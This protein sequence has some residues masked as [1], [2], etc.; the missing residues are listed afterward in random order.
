MNLIDLS[1]AEL[2][3]QHMKE[4][5]RCTAK[6]LLKII[7]EYGTSILPA[8]R[9]P[10][11]HV[12]FYL[13][14]LDLV[15]IDKTNYPSYTLCLTIKGNNISSVESAFNLSMKDLQKAEKMVQLEIERA[16]WDIWQ[17]KWGWLLGIIAGLISGF[18]SAM[19][20]T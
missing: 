13:E 8:K 16:E 1:I 7:D 6:E 18:L 17:A 2:M 5:K 3:L 14:E 20:F 9:Y 10:I 11:S 4:E 15:T 19:I 12:I